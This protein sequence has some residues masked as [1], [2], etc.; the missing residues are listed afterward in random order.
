MTLRTRLVIA[1]VLLTTVGLA[2]FGVS[3]YTLYRRALEQQLDQD[4]Q[5]NARGQSFRL[6]SDAAQYEI[7]PETCAP[8]GVTSTGT[9]G[10]DPGPG[11]GSRAVPGQ[12][13]DAYAELRTSDGTI[14]ACSLPVTE[15][16][17]PDLPETIKVPAG[18]EQYF[19][20]GS[21]DGSGAWRVLA[22]HP[23]TPPGA[24]GNGEASPT[25]PSSVTRATVIVAVRTEGLEASLAQLV[26]IELIAAVFLLTAL[27][28]GA[29]FV[30]RRGLRPLEEMADSAATITAGDLSERVE[31]ADDHTE[32]G[33]L[34]LALNTM[35]DGIEESFR[36]RDATEQ[37]L[38]QFLADASHELRTPLTSIQGFAEL[39]RLAAAADAAG[40]A[41]GIERLDLPVMLARIE[42]DADRMKAL[43]EDLLLLAR[44]DEPRTIDPA[45]VDLTVL[46]SEACSAAAALHPERPIT[47]QAP[48][49]VEVS[50]V[51]DHL[52]RAIVNLVNNAM[53]HTSEDTAIEV[54]VAGNTVTRRATVTVRDHGPGLSDEALEHVFDR[55]WQADSARVGAGSG[56]GLSIVAGIATEHG[57]QATA[58][59]APDGGAVF[60]IELPLSPSR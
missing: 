16:G 30:L 54:T 10:I 29:W 36:E 41:G 57:G 9:T 20:V 12:G 43:V 11:F 22:T 39:F 46:A 6:A 28:A 31:P 55:F 56:L 34:G 21:V 52:H 44:L 26:R 2:V 42:Q 13:L 32:V 35:L 58:T 49:P 4:L 25:T 23:G 40:D 53:K 5:A 17:R 8:V 33:Q 18:E 38:R 15:S 7:D 37:R 3:T 50:G 48:L 59:N 51:E 45:P 27:G 1:L 19:D 60:T 14:V 24:T 47:F